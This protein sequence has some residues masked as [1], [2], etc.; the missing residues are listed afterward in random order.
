MKV[1][2]VTVCVNYSSEL[3]EVADAN[4]R[5]LDRWIVVTTPQDKQTLN[6][7]AKYSIET[8][9]STEVE[10]GGDFAKARLINKGL[11]MLKGDSWLLHLDADMALPLDFHQCLDDAYLIPGNIYGSFRLCCPGPVCWDSIRAQGLYSRERNWL[12]EFRKRHPSCYVGGIPC[13]PGVGYTPI[14]FFQLWHGSETLVHKHNRKMYPITHG[15][16]A[17]T[18]T[19]FAMLWD[20]ANR[21]LIPELMCFHLEHAEAKEFMGYNWRGRKTPPFRS[22]EKLDGAVKKGY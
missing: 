7:C 21:I 9:V 8:I 18:D 15:N 12:V 4:R 3:E 16:A 22:N 11:R 19:Q 20:R 1:E 14:G 6:V 10:R 2:A 17:R 13:G 5:L